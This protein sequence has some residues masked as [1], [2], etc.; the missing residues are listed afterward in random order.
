MDSCSE[1]LCWKDLVELLGVDRVRSYGKWFVLNCGKYFAPL[2][3]SASSQENRMRCWNLEC[4]QKS[5]VILS[6]NMKDLLIP[7]GNYSL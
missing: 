1:E 2:V 7:E 4:D 5:N 6:G 3:R